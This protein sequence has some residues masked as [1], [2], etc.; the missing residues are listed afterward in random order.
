MK[1]EL[2]R[3]ETRIWKRSLGWEERD[4]IEI[5]ESLR[6]VVIFKAM[7]LNSYAK[8]SKEVVGEVEQRTASGYFCKVARIS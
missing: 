7:R 5:R 4:E 3:K 6:V 1:A 2:I 8:N